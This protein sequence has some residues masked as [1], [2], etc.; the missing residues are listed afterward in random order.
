M[1][2]MKASVLMRRCKFLE[3]L[4]FTVI[5]LSCNASTNIDRVKKARDTLIPERPSYMHNAG[6]F[7]G[8]C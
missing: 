5:D 3:G 6:V 1:A 2:E 7:E 4:F 8:L